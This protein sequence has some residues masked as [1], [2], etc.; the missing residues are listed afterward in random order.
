MTRLTLPP[1]KS[2][3]LAVLAATTLSACAGAVPTLPQMMTQNQLR[4]AAIETAVTRFGQPDEITRDQD[5]RL[6]YNWYDRWSRNV[7]VPM[8][9]FIDR[10]TVYLPYETRREDFT[11]HIR[12]LV[13]DGRI[14]DLSIDYNRIG[15][16]E[17]FGI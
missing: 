2:T 13:E 5:G 17:A 4:G 12:A 15:G 1:F 7:D 11:C 10:G 6:A 3:L 16:C 8:G 9:S 14:A